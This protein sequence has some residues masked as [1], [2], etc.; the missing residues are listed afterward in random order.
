MAPTERNTKMT[1]RM[2]VIVLG[3]VIVIGLLLCTVVYT[4]DYTETAVVSSIITGKTVAIKGLTDAGLKFKWPWPVEKVTTYKA[5]LYTL[6]DAISEVRTKDQQQIIVTAYCVW[7][8]DDARKFNEQK[9][10]VE[11]GQDSLRELLAA[12]KRDVGSSHDLGDFVNTDPGKM[13]IHDIEAELLKGLKT[14]AYSDWGIEVVSVGIKTLGLPE[15]VTKKVIEAM[16]GERME[17][18]KNLRS[19]GDATAKA[20]RGRANEAAAKIVAFAQRKADSIE[21]EGYQQVADLY[22]E[23]AKNENFSMFLRYLRSLEAGLKGHTVYILGPSSNPA[24]D[25]LRKGPSL[26]TGPPVGGKKPDKDK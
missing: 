15:G 25:Y 11:D 23:Y 6:E 21:S 10:T 22:P 4:V 20:I 17:E 7:R 9:K 24:V 5:T 1:K 19:Q 13:R 12:T 8:I 14:H 3:S 2:A 16:K 18:A 26:P